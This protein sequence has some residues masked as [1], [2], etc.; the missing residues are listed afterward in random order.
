MKRKLLLLLLLSFTLSLSAIA[1]AKADSL[2]SSRIRVRILTGDDHKYLFFKVL[3]GQYTIRINK[4]DSIIVPSGETIVITRF[5]EKVAVKTN[6]SSGFAADSVYLSASGI[7]DRFSVV[8]EAGRPTPGIYSGDLQCIADMGSIIFINICDIETY[9]AGVV[10][11]EGGNGKRAEYFKTQAIIARTYTYKYFNK[12]IADRYNLCDDTH[13]Q[14]FNGIVTDT[15]ITNA[16]GDTKG[17]VIVTPDSN[18]IIAAFHSNC[19]GETSPSEYAWPS[20]QS[21]LVKVKDPW[22]TRSRNATWEKE[23]PVESWINVLERHGYSG[24]SDSTSVFDFD[25]PSRVQ[26]YVTGSFRLQFS[27][28]RSEL[29]LRSSWFS[30]KADGD[31]IKLSG[32]GYGHGVGLCQEGAI[33]MAGK[34][35]DYSEIITFYYPGVKILN[36]IDAKKSEDDR[37][38]LK[39]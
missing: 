37:T 15:I 10:K 5:N 8:T 7:N 32:R 13:C 12:H 2:L 35:K 25:Q 36:I 34:G 23:I 4:S 28:I 22:C 31:S 30:V 20:K 3:S 19:G 38:S 26:D 27:R 17:M 24:P 39:N 21:Y 14:V 18:L 1:S 33:V 16:T 11:A 9:I 29:D 6:G